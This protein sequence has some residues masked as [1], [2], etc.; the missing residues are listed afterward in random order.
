MYIIYLCPYFSVNVMITTSGSHTVGERYTL[1]CSVTG[2]TDQPTITWLDHHDDD[3]IISSDAT[4]MVLAATMN[5]DGSYSSTLTFTPLMASDAGM[6]MCRATLGDA[7]QTTSVAVTV[8]SKCIYM[9]TCKF[10]V[11]VLVFPF[12]PNHLCQC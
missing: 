3:E 6:F 4:R 5:S 12:R 9:Y 2:S 7:M 11:L 1:Q 10:S 8:E